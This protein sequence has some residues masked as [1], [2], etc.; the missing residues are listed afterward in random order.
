MPSDF[1]TVLDAPI[2]IGDSAA[3]T[4]PNVSYWHRIA[5]VVLDAVFCLLMGGFTFGWAPLEDVLTEDGK[6]SLLA[7]SFGLN[8]LVAGVYS[9]LC[10]AGE[11]SCNAQHLRLNLLYTV[12]SSILDISAFF[13]AKCEE[14]Y[15][16][17][18]TAVLA[19]VLHGANRFVRCAL[20]SRESS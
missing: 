19:G 1:E 17:R 20:L 14:K 3:P 6:S 5:L 18:N 7:G 16:P 4:A 2:A 9:H 13:G 15:G 12:A 8:L 10:S 11:T